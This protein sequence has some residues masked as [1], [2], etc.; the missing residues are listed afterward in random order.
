[1][2]DFVEQPAN[3]NCAIASNIPEIDLETFSN[4]AANPEEA[5]TLE[6]KRGQSEDKKHPASFTEVMGNELLDDQ[7]K[8]V[9]SE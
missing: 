3:Q 7:T 2:N 1:M 8:R 4:K 9:Q 5:I 6:Q